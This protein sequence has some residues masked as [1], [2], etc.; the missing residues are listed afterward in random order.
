MFG[1]L[2]IGFRLELLGNGGGWC[3]LVDRW[4]WWVVLL[5]CSMVAVGGWGL[6][7]SLD[8]GIGFCLGIRY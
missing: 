4:W 7:L 8:L 3:D 1:E 2:G 5:G 6:R